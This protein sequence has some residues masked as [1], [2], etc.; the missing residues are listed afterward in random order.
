MWA[1]TTLEL[2]LFLV[3]TRIL[4]VHFEERRRKKPTLI[5]YEPGVTKTT[6]LNLTNVLNQRTTAMN[7][8]T[9][10]SPEWIQKVWEQDDVGLR[11]DVEGPVWDVDDAADEGGHVDDREADQQLVEERVPHRRLRQH[12]DE[13]EVVDEAALNQVKQDFRR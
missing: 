3:E 9:N 5:G 4:D 11:P 13:E 7:Q 10:L 8:K 6:D 1:T 2:D 12:Q